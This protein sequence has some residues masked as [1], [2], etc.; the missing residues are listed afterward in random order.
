MKKITM[1]LLVCLSLAACNEQDI[2]QVE[3]LR[4]VYGTLEDFNTVIKAEPARDI[5][6]VGKIYVFNELLF[7][8]EAGKG[9]HVYD[10][11]DQSNPKPMKFITIPGNIDI[12]IKDR[13]IYADLSTGIATIDISDLENVRVTNLDD[14][15]ISSVSQQRP[16]RS[17]TSEFSDKIYFECIDKS[18]GL[19]IDW[20]KSLMPKPE[21]YVLN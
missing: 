12:A 1:A 11:T 4:P 19:I 8:N 5:D 7:I 17:I 10:N 13:F 16:P 6:N 14:R 20:E 3:G 21:C 15:Y 9:V 2:E 18:K